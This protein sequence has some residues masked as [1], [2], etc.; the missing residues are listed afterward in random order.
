MSAGTITLTNGSAIVGGAGPHFQLNLLQVILLLSQ[1]GG[2][3][4]VAS[5]NGRW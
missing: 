1:V 4:Y 2:V 5:K 3:P